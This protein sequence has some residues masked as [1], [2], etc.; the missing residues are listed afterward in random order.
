M[1]LNDP[2]GKPIQTGKLNVPAV[3]ADR[4]ATCRWGTPSMK[5]MSGW[6]AMG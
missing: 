4:V 2:N 1:S 6:A 3:T 5:T